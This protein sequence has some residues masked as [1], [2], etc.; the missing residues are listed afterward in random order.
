MIFRDIDIESND[1]LAHIA[2]MI[3]NEKSIL[4]IG[5]GLGS[6]GYLMQ[7]YGKHC[8]DGIDIDSRYVDFAK[9]FY[10][11]VYCFNVEN[12]K[13]HSVVKN[14]YDAIV[15][16]DLIEHLY[17]PPMFLRKLNKCLNFSGSLFLSVPNIGHIGV[18]SELLM[19]RFGYKDFGILDKTH[20]RFFTRQSLNDLLSASGLR[21]LAQDDVK[22]GIQESGFDQKYYE[23]LPFPVRTFLSERQ[24]SFV[25]QFIVKA[26]FL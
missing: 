18:I 11:D 1:A 9:R 15:V 20:I 4:D 16:A 26:V 24:D 22:V 6:F 21:I 19:G 25:Q 2:R 7:K 8:V 3:T 17:N 14:K 23:D 10:N 5:C 13:I 12:E